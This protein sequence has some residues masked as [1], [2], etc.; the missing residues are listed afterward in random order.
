MLRT[1]LRSLRSVR[2]R[3]AKPAARRPFASSCSSHAGGSARAPLAGTLALS[4]AFTTATWYIKPELFPSFPTAS[5]EDGSTY[6][7][8]STSTPF[9]TSI[10]SPS[11]SEELLVGTGLK[12]VS[13]LNIR[14]YA[15]GIYVQTTALE[16]I[17]LG[18]LAGWENGSALHAVGDDLVGRLFDDKYDLAVTVVPLRST[19]LSHLRDAFSRALVQ[20]LKRPE[21]AAALT[22]EETEEASQS[23]NELRSLFPPK[24][25][26]KGSP[27]VIHFSGSD[28]SIRFSLPDPNNP[29]SPEE[30]LG[31][32][33]NPTLTRQLFIHL[34]SASEELRT[35]VARG[36]AGEA[37]S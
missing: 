7:D 12:C 32:L 2:V 30:V 23:L 8:P 10:T 31:T 24:N 35:S 15:A 4:L 33:T 5:A 21:V 14:V 25:I 16:R 11:G 9:P 17:R 19:T 6:K 27:L 28:N 3:P 29:S 36:F 22:L 18:K 20:R 37:R 13:F 26:S 1:S 34:A